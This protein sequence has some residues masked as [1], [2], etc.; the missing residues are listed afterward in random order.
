MR[1]S[2]SNHMYEFQKY[3]L[4]NLIYLRREENIENLLFVVET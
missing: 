2:E 3:R 4:Q 1:M